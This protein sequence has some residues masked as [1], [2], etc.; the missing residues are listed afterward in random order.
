MNSMK[1]VMGDDQQTVTISNENGSLDLSVSDVRQ[2]LAD[3]G[4]LVE[5]GLRLPPVPAMPVP[6]RMIEASGRLTLPSRA[7]TT[8]PTVAGAGIVVHSY[9]MGHCVVALSPEDCKDWG[10]WLLGQHPILKAP[11]GE[12]LN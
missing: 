1:I 2:I 7:T 6:D 5:A 10:S 12:T 9:L 4:P 11:P 3:I 8:D